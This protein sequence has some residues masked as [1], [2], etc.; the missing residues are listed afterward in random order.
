MTWLKTSSVLTK[1]QI[2][3]INPLIW[4]FLMNS[5]KQ[6]LIVQYSILAL[7]SQFKSSNSLFS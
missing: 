6:I 5:C 1:K 3:K 2:S 7:Y 4:T